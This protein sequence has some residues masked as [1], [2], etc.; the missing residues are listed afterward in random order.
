MIVKNGLAKTST[1]AY[2]A[3]LPDFSAIVGAEPSKYAGT[4]PKGGFLAVVDSGNALQSK[5]R[6]SDGK[7]RPRI[8]AIFG[9][10]GLKD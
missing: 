5:I 3:F 1:M 8:P 6:A 2:L 7:I 4:I 10:T 9:L